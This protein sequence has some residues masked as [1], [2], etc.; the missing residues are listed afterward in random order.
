MEVLR[1]QLG[2]VLQGAAYLRVCILGLFQIDIGHRPQ[3]V[4]KSR[5]SNQ[6]NG[7]VECRERFPMVARKK[8]R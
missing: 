7:S 5:I 1:G 2:P 3:R 4:E 6:T 8:L